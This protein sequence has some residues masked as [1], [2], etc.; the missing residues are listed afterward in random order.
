FIEPEKFEA[1]K[2]KLRGWSWV[3]P[4]REV[5]AYKEA[6]RAGLVSTGDVID[7]TANGMDVDDVVAAI[8]RDNALFG[9]AGIRRDTEVPSPDVT[10]KAAADAAAAADTGN[11]AAPQDD[12]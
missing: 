9:A 10:A 3:D 1:V 12:E 2:F 4:T 6:I 11:S 7:Q 5:A 8:S